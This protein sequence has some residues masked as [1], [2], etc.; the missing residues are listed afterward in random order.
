MTHK[1][2]GSKV[3]SKLDATS[4][5]WRIP[6]DEETA[7]L[8]IFLTPFGRYF[9][10]RFPFG[11]SLAPEVFQRTIENILQG[12]KGVVCFMDDVVISD[13]SVEEDDNRLEVLHRVTKA[14][15]KLNKQK[16]EFR[17]E[18]LDFLGHTSTKDG[19]QPDMSKV[20]AIQE[21]KEPERR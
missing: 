16:C 3:F 18:K 8:T 7:K 17:K 10:T 21:M 5:F 9:F 11:I 6:F 12:I 14:G 13:D 15:L 20:K 1:P 19:I 4:G 2:A